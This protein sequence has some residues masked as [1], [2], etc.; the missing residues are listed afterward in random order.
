MRVH[1]AGA[2]PPAGL[3]VASA[4]AGAGVGGSA[5]AGAGVG[6]SATLVPPPVSDAAA[7]GVVSA[8]SV[9][10]GVAVAGAGARLARVGVGATAVGATAVGVG[11]P[12]S[13]AA[14][15]CASRTSTTARVIR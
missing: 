13:H 9:L 11:E 6:V 3:W 7:V 2:L 10:S 8:D 14:N 15:N 4:C 12:L 1:L 5:C